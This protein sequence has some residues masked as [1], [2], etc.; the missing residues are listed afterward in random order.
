M[1]A[2]FRSELF[3]QRTTRSNL[4]LL[5]AMAGLIAAVVLLHMVN[6]PTPSLSDREGQLKVFGLGT[7]FG[8]IFAALLGAMAITGEFRSGLIRPTFLATPKRTVVILAK[9]AASGISGAVLGV[10]AEG[11]ALGLGSAALTMRGI[12]IAPT[13]SD[14]AQLLVGGGLA[15]AFLAMIGVGIGAVVRNQ[16]GAA[17]GLVVWLLFAEMTLIGSLPSI[18]KFLPGATGGA[19]AGAMLEQTSTYLLATAAGAV[20]MVGYVALATAAGLVTTA[21]RDVS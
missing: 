9:V 19:L 15:A 4:G 11:V 2:Q 14:L 5:A 21:R 18:G 12:H 7:T 16:V 8:M 20:L 13:A 17:V 3:K 1:R 10:I 6:L